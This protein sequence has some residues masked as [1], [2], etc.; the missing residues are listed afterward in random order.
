MAAPG[1]WP[2]QDQWGHPAGP[3]PS[4]PERRAVGW[5]IAGAILGSLALIAGAV[6]VFLIVTDDEE[7]GA[8]EVFLEPATS[9][10]PDPF[11]A[12]VATSAVSTTTSPTTTTPPTTTSSGGIPTYDG[13]EPG[14]YG[15]TRDIGSCNPTQL[16][17]FL[18]ENPSKARAWAAVLRIS[19]NEIRSYVG[20]LTTVVLRGD[21]RVTNHGYANGMATTIASV[22]QAG[23]AVLVNDRGE[24]VVKCACGNPLTAPTPIRSPSYTG[25]R[26]P[27]F[28]TT[29]IVVIRRSTTVIEE[30]VLTGPDGELFTRPV[31]GTGSDDGPGPDTTTPTSGTTQTTPSSSSST[32]TTTASSSTT[33]TT[34]PPT[35]STTRPA[36]AQ[37]VGL[38]ASTAIDGQGVVGSQEWTATVT[39]GADGAVTGSGSGSLVGSGV[40]LDNFAQ[41]FS[42]YTARVSFAVTIRGTASGQVIDATASAP[43]GSLDSVTYTVEGPMN[44]ACR[45]E[46][47]STY[48]AFVNQSMGSFSVS[49]AAGSSGALQADF[50]GTVTVTG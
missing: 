31:G 38:S 36:A 22:L 6:G 47:Q 33:T 17:E 42:E 9:T 25:T 16:V 2:P 48:L 7:A 23:T 4:P 37:Q 15:G 5:I 29:S 30:F 19:P 35:T 41:P 12:S 32:T 24:P 49:T 1:G 50:P 26:W 40:C 18:E 46:A 11:T 20:T 10:G 39:I 44:D 34:R 28:R 13:G 3:P 45:A 27:G 14:L 43:S 21:T 8:S